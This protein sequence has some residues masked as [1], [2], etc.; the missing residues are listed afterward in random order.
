MLWTKSK[1]E[2]LLTCALLL[3][4]L[5]FLHYLMLEV[6]IL[7]EGLFPYNIIVRILSRI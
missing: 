7:L 4:L 6:V 5:E 2:M 1:S 3:L